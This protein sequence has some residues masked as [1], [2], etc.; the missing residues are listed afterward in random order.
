MGQWFIY[1]VIRW[2]DSIQERVKTIVRIIGRECDEYMGQIWGGGSSKIGV[3]EVL[4]LLLD[5]FTPFLRNIYECFIIPI[6]DPVQSHYR[7]SIGTWCTFRFR[8]QRISS[9]GLK[10]GKMKKK[11]DVWQK[12]K[13]KKRIEVTRRGSF[14]FMERN[15]NNGEYVTW[16]NDR[17]P[18]TIQGKQRSSWKER[19]GR[20]GEECAF[21][22]DDEWLE[23][24]IARR[25]TLKSYDWA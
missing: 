1:L 12:K 6:S 19:R 17:R 21:H 20:M 8:S 24:E 23:A 10:Y 13:K 25:A 15:N 9:I 5:F 2:L 4:I 7:V 3:G 18:F 14:E 16:C 22:R 11:K